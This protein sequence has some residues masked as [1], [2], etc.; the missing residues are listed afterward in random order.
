VLE[1][2]REEEEELA[3]ELGRERGRGRGCEEEPTT[4]HAEE[5]NL[6]IHWFG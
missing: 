2:V 6:Y 3:S 1:V 5:G 4:V